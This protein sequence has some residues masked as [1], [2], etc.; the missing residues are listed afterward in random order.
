MRQALVP[1]CVRTPTRCHAPT[2]P[3]PPCLFSLSYLNLYTLLHRN[4]FVLHAAP[5][6]LGCF[7]RDPV[8]IASISDTTDWCWQAA[9]GFEDYMYPLFQVRIGGVCVLLFDLA[10]STENGPV[11]ESAC[12]AD[13]PDVSGM[14]PDQL[15]P[16]NG[17]FVGLCLAAMLVQCIPIHVPGCTVHS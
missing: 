2:G 1:D 11:T 9:A 14:R 17:V 4:F 3:S 6:Y 16:F 7:R 12:A 10:Q 13:K 8:A 5:A 15:T